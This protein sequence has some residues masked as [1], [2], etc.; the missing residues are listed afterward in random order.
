MVI[1]FPQRRAGT[2][3]PP[4]DILHALERIDEVRQ[5]WLYELVGAEA[6]AR[7]LREH[8]L[9]PAVRRVMN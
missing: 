2:P 9:E 4:M 6:K 8:Q 3:R 5:D 1:A 7:L